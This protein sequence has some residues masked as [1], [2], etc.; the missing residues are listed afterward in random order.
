MSEPVRMEKAQIEAMVRGLRQS[1]KPGVSLDGARIHLF[2]NAMPDGKPTTE[3][4]KTAAKRAEVLGLERQRYTGVVSR[5]FESKAKDLCLTMKVEL[6]RA[7]LDGEPV[8][9]TFNVTKG[10]VVAI[11]VLEK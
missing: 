1:T 10:D 4:A 5:V 3:A 7:S 9:R 6:E 11:A 8:F 2:Y